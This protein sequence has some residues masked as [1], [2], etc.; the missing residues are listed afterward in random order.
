MFMTEDQKKYY[1]AM[2]KMGKKKPVKAIPRPRVW[3]LANVE[4]F[5]NYHEIS[6]T[7]LLLI[8]SCSVATTGHRVRDCDQQEVR[9]DHH[10]LH[11]AEHA[12][13]DAGPLRPV[14]DVGVRP[15]EPQH[16][17][18]LHLHHRVL[19]QDIRPASPLLQRAL[20]HF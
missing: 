5:E 13:H 18:H 7:P 11:R 20:E 10:D 14:R 12:H 8:L 6:L 3:S 17:L 4:R 19:P 2:K 15:R 16:G 1:A 9:H